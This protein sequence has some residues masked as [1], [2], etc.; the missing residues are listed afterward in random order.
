MDYNSTS[1]I[2][3]FPARTTVTTVNISLINDSIVEGPETFDL[4][5]TIPVSLRGQV[6]LG[7]DS[8]AIGNIT[9][10]TGK[11]IY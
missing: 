6:I 10:D 3:T 1:V 8:K 4:T 7:T 5:I 11:M 9:D 2:A